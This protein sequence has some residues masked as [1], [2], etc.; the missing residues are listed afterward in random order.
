MQQYHEVL[1]RDQHKMF[2]DKKG[3]EYDMYHISY[4]HNRP[5]RIYDIDCGNTFYL[6]HLMGIYAL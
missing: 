3:T 4:C 1:R 2:R 5:I 6:R